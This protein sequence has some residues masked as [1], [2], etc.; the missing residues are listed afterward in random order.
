MSFIT[1]DEWSVLERLPEEELIALAVEMD[2]VVPERIEGR[3]LLDRCVPAI[4]ER[5]RTQ[6]L[7]FS[8]YD[9]ED[10]QALPD[11]QLRAIGRLQGL[12]GKV[13]VASVLKAGKAVYK[14]YDKAGGSSAMALMLPLLLPAVARAAGRQ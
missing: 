2:I 12:K 7:P 13:S 5:A 10:L 3:A 6:G 9:T 11:D 1:D 14:K 4:V 8:K